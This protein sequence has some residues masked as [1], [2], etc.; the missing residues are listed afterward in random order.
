MGG[1]ITSEG[2]NRPVQNAKVQLATISGQVMSST[3][4]AADGRFSFTNLSQGEYT[5]TVTAEGYDKGSQNVNVFS[6][7]VPD[8]RLT[9]RKP[10]NPG[11]STL[12]GSSSVSNRELLLPQKAQEALR[13]GMDTL[14]KKN[15]ASGSMPYFQKVL[16]LAP[17]FYEA[18]YQ[19]GMAYKFEGKPADAELDFQKAIATSKDTYPDADF[20]LAAIFSD[21]E[22][23]KESEQLSRHGLEMQTDSWRGNFE[24]AR[25]LYGLGQTREAEQ[26]AL[27]ARTQNPSFSD[28]YIVLANIHLQLHND[29]A[30][31]D[32]LGT[33]LKLDPKGPFAPQARD[34]MAKTEKVI[35]NKGASG[36]GALNPN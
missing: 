3:F 6:A 9:L 15:D 13:K 28:L 16:S 7:S 19:E 10:S 25:A 12:P 23:F 4:T 2:D 30:L 22:R 29:G 27:E 8:V 1:A 18:Y 35:K 24:L 34:L 36:S 11:E 31:V 17:D 21:H 26:H 32:D 33:Y 14:Y 5:I 20:G